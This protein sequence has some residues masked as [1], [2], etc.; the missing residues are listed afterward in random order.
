MTKKQEDSAKKREL[1]DCK[2][3]G[4]AILLKSSL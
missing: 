3:G 1:P 2:Q 4:T